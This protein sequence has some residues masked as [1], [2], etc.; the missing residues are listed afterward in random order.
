MVKTLKSEVK[1]RPTYHEMIGMTEEADKENRPPIE[2]S[3][4]RRATVFRNNQ[5]G[6]QLDNLEF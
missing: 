5:F 6:S 3:I 1:L 2:K 4:D